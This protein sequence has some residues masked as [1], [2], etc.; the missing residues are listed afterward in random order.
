MCP[1]YPA[2]YTLQTPTPSSPLAGW[3]DCGGW[4]RVVRGAAEPETGAGEGLWRCEQAGKEGREER[5]ER[6]AEGR[7]SPEVPRGSGLSGLARVKAGSGHPKSLQ[8]SGVTE[9]CQ[10]LFHPGLGMLLT[11]SHPRDKAIWY[12]QLC[13]RELLPQPQECSPTLGQGRVTA[14]SGAPLPTLQE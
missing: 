1:S 5:L 8:T 11:C 10:M 9:R 2:S 14:G 6:G 13:P 7:P 12:R 3:R 4:A